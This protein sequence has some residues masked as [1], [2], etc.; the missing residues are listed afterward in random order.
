MLIIWYQTIYHF[1]IIHIF[2]RNIYFFVDILILHYDKH[3]L[4]RHGVSSKS[5]KGKKLM[6]TAKENYFVVSHQ[7]MYKLQNDKHFEGTDHG[8]QVPTNE[9]STN[10][11]SPPTRFPNFA[12]TMNESL[13]FET[14][15]LDSTPHT[16]IS[17]LAVRHNYIQDG[18]N[19]IEQLLEND[20]LDVFVN[21]DD[22]LVPSNVIIFLLLFYLL[23]I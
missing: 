8:K 18:H 2:F 22:T 9:I 7:K 3:V 13:I 20:Q 11:D 19:F 5:S 16:Q 6:L 17:I 15:V 14:A 21:N 10:F 23:N 4:R 1:I 12:L